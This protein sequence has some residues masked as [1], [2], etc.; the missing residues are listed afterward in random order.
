MCKFMISVRSID[1]RGPLAIVKS[2]EISRS[3]NFDGLNSYRDLARTLCGAVNRGVVA[4]GPAG[5]GG[6]FALAV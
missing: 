6:A 4:G 1:R 5:D 2:D 3:S